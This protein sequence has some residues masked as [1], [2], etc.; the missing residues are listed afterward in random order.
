[1][2]N[3][4]KIPVLALAFLFLCSCKTNTSELPPPQTDVELINY[5]QLFERL[6]QDKDVT[7]VVNFWATWCGPCVE[8]LPDFLE[9]NQ[10]YAGDKEFKMY[11]IT[12]DFAKKKE[13]LV[14]PFIK[15]N[16]IRAE[17]LLLDDNKR[18]NTWIPL[19]DD[20]WSGALPATLV[21]KEGKVQ[22]F[23]EGSM[24]KKELINQIKKLN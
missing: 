19:F 2:T 20:N 17:V 15:N 14:L 4:I 10:M 24:T 21:Y 7:Y 6:N 9:V 5:E 12:L 8:E 3:V 22:F 18:M 16:D 11:L 23:K 1:M 13:E